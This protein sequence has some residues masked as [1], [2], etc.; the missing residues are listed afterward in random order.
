M[1]LLKQ[2]FVMAVLKLNIDGRVPVVRGV[3]DPDHVVSQLALIVVFVNRGRH[4]FTV[5]A[6]FRV[7][8]HDRWLIGVHQ[9]GLICRTGTAIAMKKV[10]AKQRTADNQNRDNA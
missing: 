6:G 3:T 2:L 8:H 7:E 9:L 10:K 1:V 4:V 5:L